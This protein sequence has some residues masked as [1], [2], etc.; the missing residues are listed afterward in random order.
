M[1]QVFGTKEWAASN[2]NCINGCSHDCHY[3][4]AKTMALRFHRKT[5]E[6]W[7]EEERRDLKKIGKR[8]GRIM[9]PTTHDITPSNSDYCF[10]Y[11]NQILSAGNQVLI[12]SKPHFNVIANLCHTFSVYKDK[13]LLRFTMGTSSDKLA[14]WEPGAPNFNERLKALMVAHMSGFQTSVSCEPMLDTDMSIL[15][16]AVRPY[17]TDCVWLGI[18]NSPF[19]RLKING[20]PEDVIE[21]AKRLVGFYDDKNVKKLYDRYK[22]DSL[23]KWKESIKKIVG[24]EVP[25]EKGLD[26]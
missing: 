2:A 21:E 7:K 24:I 19:L 22:N 18:M 14:L 8:Q 9:F 11:L 4:Y 13:I 6:S 12:V 26:I 15:I 23:I 25:E 1:K 3:C 17:V 10:E 5:V 16:E 20:A